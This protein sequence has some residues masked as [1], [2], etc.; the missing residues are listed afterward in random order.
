VEIDFSGKKFAFGRAT[1]PRGQF[2]LN[3]AVKVAQEF[4]SENKDKVLLYLTTA[5]AD[6]PTGG[7]GSSEHESRYT[8]WRNC[9]DARA[10]FH[11]PAA[12]LIKIDEDAVLRF[13]SKDDHVSSIILQGS[14][15][16]YVAIDGFLGV[17]VGINTTHTTD[18]GTTSSLGLYLMGRGSLS[19]AVAAAYAKSL[20]VNA[21]IQ[22]EIKFRDDPWFIDHLPFLE[23]WLFPPGEHE[24]TRTKTLSCHYFFGNNSGCSWTDVEHLP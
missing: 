2:D 10:Q 12:E 18:A 15:P 11:F 13:R 4:L 22:T 8:M 3:Q 19:A 14:D 23:I 7:C 20:A 21:G 24:Y 6:A 9:Y 17:V 1:I 16:R 5:P